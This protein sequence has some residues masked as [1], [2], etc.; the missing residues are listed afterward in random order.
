M[1]PPF[2][3]DLW[4]AAAL[5]SSAA[6][7]TGAAHAAI[8]PVGI[9][10]TSAQSSAS[11]DTGNTAHVGLNVIP[12]QRL[13]TGNNDSLH[14][15]FLDQSALTLGPD[16]ELTIDE[17]TYDAET[18]KGK[19]RL[20]LIRGSLRIV[21]GFIS[22]NE[23]AVITTP[24]STVEVLGGISL[25]S[26]RGNETQATFL[27]GQQ[28]RVSNPSGTQSVTRPG[29]SVN[30]NQNGPSAPTRM[31]PQQL[32]SQL[33]QLEQT[34]TPTGTPAPTSPTPVTPLLSTS[35]RQGGQNL[36][37]QRLAPDRITV[38]T[39]NTQQANPNLTLNNLLAT[40]SNKIA[41]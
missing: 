17:F 25:V 14:A 28:M 6:L 5:T 31:S 35:D 26:V 41:S 7:P 16:S 3:R 23:A 30:S 4:L 20:N 10:T 39:D 19:I 38:N 2:Y 32:T 34:R 18:Q 22:K 8:L 29:F 11:G 9:V 21:G 37:N 40:G 27:F 12:G 33:S 36:P 1:S 15:L 13:Q 24:F